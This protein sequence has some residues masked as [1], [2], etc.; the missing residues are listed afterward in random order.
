MGEW[1]NTTFTWL[2]G[3]LKD[4]VPREVLLRKET[5]EGKKYMKD[6]ELGYEK[7]L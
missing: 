2:L 6:L 4:M 3:Y 7:I 1:S 5:Y